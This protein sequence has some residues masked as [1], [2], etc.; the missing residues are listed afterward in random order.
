MLISSR[1]NFY[2]SR[3]WLNYGFTTVTYFLVLMMCMQ[4]L[5]NM[6]SYVS[7]RY[8]RAQRDWNLLESDVDCELRSPKEG[9]AIWSLG[10]GYDGLSSEFWLADAWSNVWVPDSSQ[11]PT[12]NGTFRWFSVG[13]NFCFFAGG[14]FLLQKIIRSQSNLITL[15]I[16]SKALIQ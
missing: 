6:L 5:Y 14:M 9:T 15:S 3:M 12:K 16:S 7:H 13:S 8:C 10:S 1:K 4:C 11:F 2:H